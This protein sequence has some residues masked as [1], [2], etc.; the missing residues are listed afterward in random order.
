[1]DFKKFLQ[2]GS[3]LGVVVAVAASAAFLFG[4]IGLEL[5]VTLLGLGGFSGLAGLRSAIQSSGF[6]TYIVAA[7]GAVVSVLVGAEFVTPEAAV[8]IFSVLG[9]GAVPTTAH[10]VKKKNQVRGKK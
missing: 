1:M 6:K 7:G 5:F 4:E 9:I 3:I 2:G 8:V 10:A